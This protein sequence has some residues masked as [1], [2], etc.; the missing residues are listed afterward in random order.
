MRTSETKRAAVAAAA[1]EKP[2]ESILAE[3]S[4]ET[5]RTRQR[6]LRSRTAPWQMWLAFALSRNAAKFYRHGTRLAADLLRHGHAPEAVAHDLALV[7]EVAGHKDD[8]MPLVN[9]VALKEAR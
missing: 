9:D 7:A 2:T 6:A 4:T 1:R 5:P 3:D 8:V